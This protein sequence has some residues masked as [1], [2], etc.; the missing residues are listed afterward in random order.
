[1]GTRWTECKEANWEP[2]FNGPGTAKVPN[3]VAFITGFYRDAGHTIKDLDK[4]S[5]CGFVRG[6]SAPTNNLRV[7]YSFQESNQQFVCKK[8]Q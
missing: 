6:Y 4:A 7:D 5:Y 3:D 1:V 2:V 8:K